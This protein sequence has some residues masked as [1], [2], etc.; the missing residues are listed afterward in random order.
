M[1]LWRPFAVYSCCLSDEDDDSE[2]GDFRVAGEET[3]DRAGL[4][5]H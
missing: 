2:Y 1:G 3:D 5:V 4:E